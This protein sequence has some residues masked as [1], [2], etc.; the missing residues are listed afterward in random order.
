VTARDAVTCWAQLVPL[1]IVLPADKVRIYLRE[2]NA[3][4]ATQEAWAEMRSRGVAWKERYTKHARIELAGTA[5]TRPRPVD[6]GMDIL[7]E[8]GPQAMRPGDPLVFQ[9]L[10]DG[11]PLADFAVELCSEQQRLGVWRRTD[12][13]GRV[14]LPAPPAGRW[15][16]RGTDLRLSQSDADTWESRFVTLAFSIAP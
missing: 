8:S 14:R 9:V 5:S 4:R 1:D 6:M 13:D 15:V 2:I 7:M 16:L 12:A 10:R 11:A 3:S